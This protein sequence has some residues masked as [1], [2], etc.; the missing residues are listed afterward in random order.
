MVATPAPELTREQRRLTM[1]QLLPTAAGTT[2]PAEVGPL[3][4]VRQIVAV[5]TGSQAV[6][7]G[8]MLLGGSGLLVAGPILQVFGGLKRAGTLPAAALAWFTRLKP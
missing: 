3:T 8:A 2:V 4:P 6:P 5:A 7:P 1:A